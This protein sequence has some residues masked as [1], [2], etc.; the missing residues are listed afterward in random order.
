[1]HTLK[2]IAVITLRNLKEEK[3]FSIISILGVALGVGLFISILGTTQTAINSFT[4][5]IKK[6]NPDTNLQVVSKFGK[7]FDESVYKLLIRHDYK[8]IPVVK[9]NGL[10]EKT[11][12]SINLFG[13][14]TFSAF[15]QSRI[16]ISPEKINIRIF[17]KDIDGAILT[18]DIA[19]RIGVKTGDNFSLVIGNKKENYTVAGILSAKRIPTGIYQDI[20]NFQEKLSIFGKLSRIDLESNNADKLNNILPQSVRLV[21]KAGVIKNEKDILE[22]FKFNL[23]FISFI[24]ILVGFFMLYNTIFITVV[25][26][27]PQIGILRALGADKKQIIFLFIV[28]SIILGVIGSFLGLFLGQILSFYSSKMVEDTVTTIFKPVIIEEMFIFSSYALVAFIIGLAISLIAAVLP[29]IEASRVKPTET[30]REG[31]FELRYRKFYKKAFILG[32]ILITVGICF[33]L[34]DY[35]LKIF[36]QPFFSYAGV[37]LILVGFAAGSPYYL[38]KFLQKSQDLLKKIFRA[39]GTISSAD[40]YSSLY[41]FSIALISV[42]VSTALIISMMVLINSFETSLKH[43]INKNLNADIFIKSSSCSS[44]FCFEPIDNNILSKI[45]N[46]DGIAALNPFMA[47]QGKFRGQDVIYGFGNEKVVKQYN[48]NMEDYKVTDSVAVSEYIKIKYGIEKDEKI[49]ID[50]PAGRKKFRVREVFTSYSTTQGFIIFDKSFQKKYWNSSAFTQL[51]IFL[52]KNAVTEKVIKKIREELGGKYTLDI[53]NNK[54]LRQKVMGIFNNSFQIT[55]AIQLTALIISLLGVANMLYAVALERKRE[56]SILKYLGADNKFLTKIYMISA[57]F[58]GFCGII[59]GV[60]LGF[61]L[62]FIIIKVVNTISFGW[63]IGIH[64]NVISIFTTLVILLIF[65]IIA[66]ILPLKTIKQTDPKK[67]VSY[68]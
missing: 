15:K 65:V 45:K 36:D 64:L 28:Q 9:T 60:I 61:I 38:E 16:R 23:H 8:P 63:S 37:L 31:T 32:I 26:K 43:W 66:G 22:S 49:L 33:S 24:A 50:T 13:I 57:G 5:D 11:D 19:Q 39:P 40:V 4:E 44:N 25:K 47:M 54:V 68:E 12:T 51:S 48:D 46:I 10:H 2:L 34:A 27:R 42:T 56:I 52:K 6:L 67:S 17:L 3:L 21:S 14:D 29:A 62:S 7:Y 18:N 58:I 59:Y 53:L 35:Y 1:M 20:G 41:R 30:V 55:Y